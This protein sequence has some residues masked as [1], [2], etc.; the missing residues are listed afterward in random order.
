M[1]VDVGTRLAQY[2]L[3]ALLGEGGMGRVFQARDTKLGR[4]VA[5]KVLPEAVADDAD[6]VARFSREAMLLAALN[7]PR[8]AAIHGLE[9]ASGHHFLVMELVG[10]ET[11]ADRLQRGPIPVDDA[12]A[13]GA[14][15]ADA[16]EAAH[17]Q[18]IIHRDL[19][20]ANIKITPDGQIKV[21]DF[22]L[23]KAMEPTASGPQPSLTA[24]PTLSLMATQAGM[25]LGTAAYMSPEQAKGLATDPRTDVFSFGV[26]LFE[27]LSGRQPF[28]GE[29]VPDILASVLA[30]EPDFAQLP[31]TVHS[32][33]RGILRR[34]LEK[35][36]RRRWQAI[37]DVRLEL[38]SL[39][40]TPAEENLQI[41]PVAVPNR[42]RWIL[43]AAAVTLVVSA[44]AAGAAWMLKP[45]PAPI[46]TRFSIEAPP[47]TSFTAV[48]GRTGVYPLVSPDGRVLALSAR[49]E[50]GQIQIWLRRL[51]ASAAH[52]LPD[53]RGA[54]VFFWSP[55]SRFLAF[56]ADGKLKKIAIDG[57]P[58]QTLSDAEGLGGGSW[59][60]TDVILLGRSNDGLVRV[61]AA[62]G[63]PQPVTRVAPGQ[64]SHRFPVFL[65]DGRHFLYYAVGERAV[66]AASLDG[67]EPTRVL[68]EVDTAAL[69][70]PSGHIVYVRAGVLLVQP[71][72]AASL[73]AEG[74]PVPIAEDV[75]QA[76]ITG[77]LGASI[78]NDGTLVFGT[79][80]FQVG[81]SQQLMWVDRQG[82]VLAE[83]GPPGVFKGIDL[84]ADDNRLVFH[85]DEGKGGDVWVMDVSR[86]NSSRLTF[87]GPDSHT[88]SPQWSPDGKD[89]VFSRFRAGKWSLWRKT[90]D[91]IGA[92]SQLV[93]SDELLTPMAWAR[94]A[95]IVYQ[96]RS[97]GALDLRILPASGAPPE[98]FQSMQG[99]QTHPQVSPDGRWLAYGSTETGR[100]E[101][102]VRSFPDGARKWLA[103]T[104]GGGLPRWRGDSRELFF[105][106]G[107]LGGGR[108]GSVEIH[109]EGNELKMSS[110]QVL[111]DTG[112]A[113]PGPDF[114]GNYHTYAVS[115]DGQRFL[116]PRVPAAIADERDRIEVIVNWASTMGR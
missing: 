34:C 36:P 89:I 84:T 93:E 106:S 49:D 32:R 7:H 14:Q 25:I 10:G 43:A 67:G 96:Q 1:N 65:N 63:P 54:S 6:R 40:E 115:R 68:N 107:A 77:F 12:V 58:P 22:G 69:P 53:T 21:L 51:N 80:P 8:I 33:L 86:G 5:V 13:L 104:A 35:N 56:V 24:S 72:D 62:G 59:S 23:A 57:G 85:R 44:I 52:P 92:E 16:L 26:V 102:Y 73:Q 75:A 70:S 100:P 74:A 114:G 38:E 101:L 15:I 4:Q 91:G 78:S 39:S 19:K 83:V 88:G 29:T 76:F 113:Q 64:L 105:L 94:D 42:S 2:E 109:V 97:G 60:P 41:Q 9:E 37:G 116:I 50:T 87:D 98:S 27:M 47:D 18:G 108:L 79:S 45:A 81:E 48:G 66:Y 103:T 11:I 55:D 71:F 90:V 46:V 61:P 95:R 20:P 82:K 111:F 3:T 17:A 110:P 28:G 112:Y 30:R 99:N 31:A